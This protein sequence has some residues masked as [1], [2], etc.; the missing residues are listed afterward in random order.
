MKSNGGNAAAKSASQAPVQLLLS[1]LAGGVIAGRR[2]ARDHAGGDGV[3]LDMGGTSA[4]VGLIAKGDFGSTTEYELEWGVPVSALFIDYTTIG[5][6]GGS[7]A[8]LDSG[9]LLR[10]GPKSAGAD[11]G[12]A[13]YGRG[14]TEPTVTDANVVLGRI[15]PGFFLGGKMPLDPEL[16]RRA[17]QGLATNLG[18]RSRTPRLQFSIRLPR[19]WP[20]RRDS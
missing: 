12:P 1:G 11:P 20:T 18:F 13:C 9:G 10:V 7:I 17:I 16:A 19:I 15:D 5:A 3:T 14:G 8:Y 2:F 6:G 4:D